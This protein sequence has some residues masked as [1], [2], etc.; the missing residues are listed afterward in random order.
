MMRPGNC[1]MAFVGVL[2]GAIAE[3]GAFWFLF[4]PMAEPPSIFY[5]S[6][7]GLFNSHYWGI[8][9]LIL[10][11]YPLIILVT[12]AATAAFLVTGAGNVLN[13]YYDRELDK[14]AHP[15]RPIP[16]GKVS[17]KD[18]WQF[19][20][21]L[22]SLGIFITML[23]NWLC[24]L[25]ALLNTYLLFIY[26][27]S[28]KAKGLSGN[29]IISYLT[30]SVFIF[31]GASVRSFLFVPIFFLL[32]LL[33]NVAR[34]ITKDIEDMKADSAYRK[35]LPMTV[36]TRGA[37]DRAIFYLW[38]AIILS[39]LPLLIMIMMPGYIW[40]AY[41]VKL[42]GYLA[43]VLVADVIF[44]YSTNLIMKNPRKAQTR[45]KLGMAIAML[46]FFLF[47]AISPVITM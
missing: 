43:I 22:F 25:I 30:A 39:F 45:M 16:S 23:V 11:D 15:E 21:I 17:P 38:I 33:A 24:L 34:E 32:A 37:S 4:A 2:I 1:A 27:R 13:D 8:L 20:L 3:L 41:L 31:G 19:A 18:A 36:G 12:L 35:T 44:I 28:Y 6:W 29:F 47:G 10:P 9:P 46:A 14:K 26:E 40:T 7:Y 5:T 42:I